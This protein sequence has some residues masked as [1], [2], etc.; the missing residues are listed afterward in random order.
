MALLRDAFFV[1]LGLWAFGE[2]FPT[3]PSSTDMVSHIL[4]GCDSISLPTSS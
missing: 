1:V 2:G 4:G 3:L